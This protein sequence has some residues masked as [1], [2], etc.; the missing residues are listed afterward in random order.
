MVT[1]TDTRR[2]SFTGQYSDRVHELLTIPGL[3]KDDTSK[4]GL[5][6]GRPKSHSLVN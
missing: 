4:M 6:T 5:N 2:G 1:A 3:G